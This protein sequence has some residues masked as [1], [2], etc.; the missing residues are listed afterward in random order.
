MADQLYGVEDDEPLPKGH[1]N[2]FLWTVFILLLIG[3]AF[4][5][6]LGSFYVFGHPEQPRAYKILKK[7]GKIEPPRRFEDIAA[8]PGEFLSAQKL[9]ERYTKFSRLEL[10]RENAEL[11]RNYINNYR[12]T[13]KLVPY[14]R[15]KF[16]ILD[17]YELQK[18]DFVA[19]GVVALAQSIDFPQVVIEHIF[20]AP[21]SNVGVV[22]KLLQTGFPFPLERTRDLSAVIHVEKVY[23][24]RLQLTVVPLLYGSYALKGGVGTFS[25]EPPPDLN[26]AGGLPIVNKQ[27]LQ[28]GL[29]RFA[30]Y[31]RRNPAPVASA[32]PNAATTPAPNSP[33]L[34][35]LDALPEGTKPPLTGALPAM[36]V[37][38]PIPAGPRIAG[39]QS[40]RTSPPLALNNPTP[41]PATVP[42]T[43]LTLP[44]PASATPPPAI[45]TVPPPVTLPEA[46]PLPRT[47]PQGVP[48]T[49]FIASN[50]APGSRT[51][52]GAT[53]RTYAP[54]QAPRAR[55]VTP[56]EAGA[57]A[58]RGDLGE[59]LYLRG[60]F[61]VTAAGENKAVLRPQAGGDDPGVPLPAATRVIVEYPGGSLPPTEGA[62]FARDDSRPLEI[63]DVRRGADGQ[64]NI[65]AREITQP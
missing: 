61:V 10:E 35:R 16:D 53:W 38:T 34:V 40:L 8:P 14:V 21:A 36:P 51:L 30:E 22:R 37:A 4:A 49:P 7:L 24:G 45:P 63:R 43:T 47:S 20:P 42:S 60:R 39:G 50:P 15:G 29:K 3:I 62:T 13:K 11:L 31:R 44:P 1:D 55:T 19:S 64:I 48:L 28:D 56:G 52:P 25:L 9:F 58:D 46:T 65:Y 2:L 6:W 5:C 27:T 59:K 32:E 18:T 17:S 54:G 57:L 41:R 26:V 12:E 33:E 23:E